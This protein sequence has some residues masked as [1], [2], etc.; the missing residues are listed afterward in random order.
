MRKIHRGLSHAGFLLAGCGNTIVARW[1][2]NGPHVWGTGRI[3]GRMLKKFAQ[4]GR[5]ERRGDAYSVRYV[6][7]LSKARTLLADFFSILLVG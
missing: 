1:K 7:P 4:Q 6:E 5:S 2:F 3:P